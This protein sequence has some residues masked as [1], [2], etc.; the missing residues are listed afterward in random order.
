MDCMKMKCLPSNANRRILVFH[1]F[2]NPLV[3]YLRGLRFSSASNHIRLIYGFCEKVVM[4]LFLGLNA[5]VYK[6]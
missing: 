4:T 3:L 5:F 2:V 6:K 1:F